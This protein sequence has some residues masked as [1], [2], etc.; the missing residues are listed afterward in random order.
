MEKAEYFGNGAKLATGR[1]IDIM[2]E[3][4]EQ[5]LTPVT[6]AMVMDRRIEAAK[7]K[8]KSLIYVLWNNYWDT[9]Y[10]LAATKDKI[11]LHPNSRFLLNS[12]QNTSLVNYGIPINNDE[13]DNSFKITE[14]KEHILN[15]RLTEQQA[16]QHKLWLE[17]AE[18]KQERLDSYVEQAFRLGKDEFGHKEIMGVYVP[19]DNQPIQR[20][21]CIDRLGNGSY[22]DGRVLDYDDARLVGVRAEGDA[23]NFSAADLER[24]VS[25]FGIKSEDELIKALR[26][27]DSAKK[28]K[29]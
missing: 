29:I 3:L 10:G 20:A 1:Y 15:E 16:R 11:Y 17:L 12:N 4:R 22:A 7:S 9:S 18:N 28:L 13:I 27:Y 2:P 6:P 26:L 14:R 5:R 23:E 24:I 19:K 25:Q 21:V 8:D